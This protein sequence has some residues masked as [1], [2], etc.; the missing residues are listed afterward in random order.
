MYYIF[1]LFIIHFLYINQIDFD[2]SGRSR[3][4][5]EVVLHVPL[6]VEVGELVAASESKE[7]GEAGIRVDLAPILLVLETLL[8]DVGVDLL[9]DLSPG[10]L[11]TN[12][13][14][15]EL[16]ELVGNPGGLDEARGLPVSSS[17]PLLG[18]LL[19]I[20]ELTAKDLLEGLVVGLHG[21]EESGHL[22]KLGAELLN[23]EGDG[24]LLGGR[25]LL[26]DDGG[27]GD[28]RRGGR[29]SGSLLL[30]LLGARLGGL[31]RLD[32]GRRGDNNILN[33]G[34]LIRLGS[35]NHVF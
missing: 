29:G 3:L 17:P 26:R 22:L 31:R 2:L 18:V 1:L 8:A 7:L 32:G 27:S 24:R 23:L 5:D 11:G 21:S 30:S 16:G 12:G 4:L 28:N 9:A 33:G 19:G 6:K 35:A 25:G 20:L 34:E 13:L 10:H 15:K 14:A